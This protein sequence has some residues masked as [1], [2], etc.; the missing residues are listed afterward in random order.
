MHC[1]PIILA[2]M[3]SWPQY[4]LDRGDSPAARRAL[5][6]PV[7]EAICAVGKTRME[8]AWLAV[9]SDAETHGARCVLEE[10]CR[11]CPR[12]A[13]CDWC[14]S[15]CRLGKPGPTSHGPWQAKI[16][17]CPLAVLA[18]TLR[19]RYKAGARC[20]LRT[21]RRGFKKCGTIEGAFAHQRGSGRCHARWAAA[22][23]RRVEAILGKVP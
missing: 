7:A 6:R 16:R 4:R 2:L 3:L 8:R 10:R 17:W 1:I 15:G 13:R 19:D 21:A 5:Y 11:D 14:Y 12:G 23:A 18:P 20:A 9:Q 22:R